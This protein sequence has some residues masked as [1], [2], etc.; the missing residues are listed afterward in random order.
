MKLAKDYIDIGV[1]TNNLEDMLAFWRDEVGLPYEELLKVGS[2]THQHRLGLNGS[3]FKLN[4]IRDPLPDSGP[5]GYQELLIASKDVTAPRS[6]KD[7]DGNQVT[8]VPPGYKGITHIGVRMK[9]SSLAKS[10]DFFSRVLEAS[11]IDDNVFRWATTV[12]FLEEDPAHQPSLEMRGTGYRYITVQVW[13]VDEEHAL[14]LERGGGE[15][16]SPVTLGT[17][18][19]I[20]FIT[21]PDNNWIEVSQRASLTGTLD[22]A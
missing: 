10:R 13:Q 20:S 2:G 12:F 21:D 16:R 11:E 4:S 14:I 5:T 22:P 15:G 7:P 9:V 18:A 3:V 6:M 8:L 1:Q 17:T 19:R